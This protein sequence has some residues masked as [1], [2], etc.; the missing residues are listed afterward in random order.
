MLTV[1]SLLS[2][3]H[4][5][6]L[7]ALTTATSSGSIPLNLTQANFGSNASDGSA[8]PINATTAI[9]PSCFA[10]PTD[11]S[12]PRLHAAILDDCLEILFD[13]LRSPTAL[14]V[15]AWDPRYKHFPVWNVFGTCAIGIVPKYPTSRDVFIEILVAHVAA[16]VIDVCVKNRMYDKVGGIAL[17]GPR[18]EFEVC[19]Y[20]RDPSAV[21][22]LG[23][24]MSNAT[25]SS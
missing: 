24:A 11:P 23:T 25:A 8:Y 1:F 19:V 5:F 6:T 7:L 21:G 15:N 18:K 22:R 3:H 16:V 17:L 13:I 2:L 10:Q 4:L 14:V 12:E 20:G 9:L